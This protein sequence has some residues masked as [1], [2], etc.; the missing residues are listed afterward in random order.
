[1]TR[2]VKEAAPEIKGKRLKRA[3][4]HLTQ[5]DRDLA[6]VIDE[7][8]PPPPRGEPP[9]FAALLGIIVSQQVS[10][11]AAQ[12]IWA[13]LE[14]ALD[15]EPTPKRLWALDEEV[16][17]A[18]GLSRQK[19]IYARGLADEILSGRLDLA[20]VARLPDDDVIAALTQVKGIGRWS[21]EIYLLFALNRPDV[22]PANDLALVLSAQRLKRLRVRP[23]PERLLRLA[24]PWRPWRSVAARLLWHYYRTF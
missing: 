2:E 1:M 21:A 8:G 19:V 16:L 20:A 17:R 12:A 5:A 7:I 22:M 3:L 10:N 9:G 18:A 24:E 23:S 13:R 15:G 14:A 11:G 6:R 4:D